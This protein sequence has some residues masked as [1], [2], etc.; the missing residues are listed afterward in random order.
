MP[1]SEMLRQ[2]NHLHQALFS[3]VQPFKPASPFG[4]R[5]GGTD[6][7]HRHDAAR[8]RVVE[9]LE[10]TTVAAI[11]R[12]GTAPEPDAAHDRLLRREFLRRFPGRGLWIY[13][14][15]PCVSQ[16]EIPLDR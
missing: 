12:R 1:I 4:Q 9:P 14:C 2:Q 8:N 3:F 10:H 6:P 13:T 16:P 15:F 5:R 11:R 7:A